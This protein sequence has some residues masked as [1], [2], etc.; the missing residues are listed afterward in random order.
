M[1]EAFFGLPFRALEGFINSLFQLMDVSLTSPRYS[2]LC[3]RVQTVDIHYRLPS[4]G[5][6]T[7]LVIDSTGLKVCGEGDWKQRKYGKSQRHIWRKLHLAVDT[8]THEIIAA[9]KGRIATIPPRK[10]A[11]YWEDGHPRN[12]AVSALKSGQLAE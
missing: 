2:C 9:Q 3:K 10:K 8:Q 6:V 7:Q 11:G 5:G 12:D 1:L 4:K